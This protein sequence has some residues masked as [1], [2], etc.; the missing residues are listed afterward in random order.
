LAIFLT[1]WAVVLAWLGFTRSG[2]AMAIFLIGAV[3][4]LAIGLYCFRSFAF[5]R[6]REF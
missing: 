2:W 4:C 1:A 6:K 5:A 3:V